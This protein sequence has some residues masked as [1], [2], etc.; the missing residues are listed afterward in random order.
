MRK[1]GYY[2]KYLN[3]FMIRYIK[4]GG[5]LKKSLKLKLANVLGCN[6]E[7]NKKIICMKR[8]W[9]EVEALISKGAKGKSKRG[10]KK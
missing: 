6:P 2:Y 3:K 1:M 7:F 8:S 10:C 4:L 5:N 9:D